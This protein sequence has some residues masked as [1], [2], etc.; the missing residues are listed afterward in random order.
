MA[1]GCLH[2]RDRHVVKCVRQTIRIECNA[3]PLT[4]RTMGGR[5]A[6]VVAS[7]AEGGRVDSWL[8]LRRFI[9]CTRSSRGIAHEGGGVTGQLDLPPL[10]PLSVAGCSRLQLGVPHWGTSVD[11]CK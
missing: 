2:D 9:P 6:K 5:I 4:H 8:R 7:H 1:I 11:Y 10:T 3:A